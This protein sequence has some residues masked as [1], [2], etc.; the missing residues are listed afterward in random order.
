VTGPLGDPVAATYGLLGDGDTAV[1]EMAAASGLALV[2][3]NRRDPR[4]TTTRGTGEL[5]RHA[6]DGGARRI[7]LGIGGS[8][9]NDAGAG[10]A[11]ALG[12]SLKDAHGNELPGGG[13]ALARLARIDSS[14]KHPALDHCEIRVACDVDNPLCG[15][16][17]ASRVYGPQK[18]ATEPVVRELDAALC[19][20]AEVVEQQF[21][22]HVLNLPG[23]G[24]AGGLGAGLVAFTRARLCPGVELIADACGLARKMQGADLV[25]TGEGCLDAQTANGK[26]PVGVARV[27]ERLNIPVVAV[28]GKLGPGYRALHSSGLSAMFSTCPGPLD[29]STAKEQVDEFLADTTES[30]ARLWQLGK[31]QPLGRSVQGHRV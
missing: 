17:G 26:A 31:G 1:I 13:A 11:Q 16:T 2:P 19:R 27:A 3:P 20:F 15:P 6:L 14:A 25:I 18:G 29:L 28:A 21:G 22:V 23:A 12:F 9:T 5:I 4:V 10:M 7:V 30:I 24:A 8:A